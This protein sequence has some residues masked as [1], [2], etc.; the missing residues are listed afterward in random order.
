MKTCLGL[1]YVWV[2]MVTITCNTITDL[3]N[4]LYRKFVLVEVGHQSSS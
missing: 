4:R 3:S 1:S 2:C